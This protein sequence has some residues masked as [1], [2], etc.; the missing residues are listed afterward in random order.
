[1]VLFCTEGMSPSHMVELGW[2]KRGKEKGKKERKGGD[3]DYLW[4]RRRKVRFQ[5]FALIRGF[6][7]IHAHEQQTTSE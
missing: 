7:T 2:K 5:A 1:M 3:G 4:Y 6:T